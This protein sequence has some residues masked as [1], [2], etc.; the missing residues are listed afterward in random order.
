MNRIYDETYDCDKYIFTA[1]P[2]PAFENNK[3]NMQKEERRIDREISNWIHLYKDS[4][5]TF[6]GDRQ[7]IS[8]A[9]YEELEQNI[10]WTNDYPELKF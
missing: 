4:L 3:E 10:C 6:W 5:R 2:L 8:D 9:E 7:I 1:I